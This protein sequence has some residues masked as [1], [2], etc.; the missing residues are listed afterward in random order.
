M[1]TSFTTLVKLFLFLLH[2][3]A[4]NPIVYVLWESK[5]IPCYKMPNYY[6]KLNPEISII[7]STPVIEYIKW[8]PGDLY[9]KTL[10]K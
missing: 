8:R 5:T 4:K 10:D 2:N 6:E 1:Q 3:F 9:V 7:T